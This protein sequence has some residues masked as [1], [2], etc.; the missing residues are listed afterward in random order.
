MVKM[1]TEFMKEQYTKGIDNLFSS[2]SQFNFNEY[3]S[4]LYD[5]KI[6]SSLKRD[7]KPERAYIEGLASEVNDYLT[8]IQENL[9]SQIR[10]NPKK[11]LGTSLENLIFGSEKGKKE[12]SSKISDAVEEIS[13]VAEILA[14]KKYKMWN[15]KC[16]IPI[17]G[18]IARM[19][20]KSI[21]GQDDL[22][23]FKKTIIKI[24]KLKENIYSFLDSL[25]LEVEDI[26]SKNEIKKRYHTKMKSYGE[27]TD[28][29]RLLAY[30][31]DCGLHEPRN[32]REEKELFEQ[33]IF[34]QWFKFNESKLGR[35]TEFEKHTD[36]QKF[37]R[38]KER[39]R[40]L[41]A[42]NHSYN[43]WWEKLI[44]YLGYFLGV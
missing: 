23:E 3:I 28:D 20:L 24:N 10:N 13:Y 6:P 25:G 34:E 19:E 22:P 42:I 17:I 5:R 12:F 21:I 36:F 2:F 14:T 43:S 32:A 18:K 33:E 9:Y 27:L 8:E 37:I 11:A 31:L 29:R 26:L 7:L 40:R 30:D 44:G 4:S 15:N 35:M 38:E 1:E 16:N 41:K 39:E